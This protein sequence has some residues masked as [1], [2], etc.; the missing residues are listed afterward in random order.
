MRFLNPL[1]DYK[2]T[3]DLNALTVSQGLYGE[4]AEIVRKHGDWYAIRNTRDAYEGY[5]LCNSLGRAETPSTHTVCTRSTLLFVSPDI[6]SRI[7]QCVPFGAELVLVQEH[8]DQFF[9]TADG[10]YVW[11]SHCRAHS[12]A[13]AHTVAMAPVDAEDLAGFAAKHFLGAPYLWGG[14]S[15]AG[16]DCSGLVQ[17]AAFAAGRG[18]PRDSGQQELHLTNEIAY[19]ERRRADL[20][21]WPG[22]VGIL[23][24]EF[25]LLHATAHS[26]QSLV[27]P[28]ITVQARAGVPSSI[29]RF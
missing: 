15:P 27:E 26:L 24:N 25:D 19:A 28:L 8:D 23:M 13:A 20:V 3:A 12:Q 16:F 29:R 17:M 11:R 21:F 14:R 5:V 7:V 4:H 22:H 9:L 10:E 18:L 2:Q 1:T 6:K